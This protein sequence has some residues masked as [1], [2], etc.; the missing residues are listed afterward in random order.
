MNKISVTVY[1]KRVPYRTSVKPS[2]WADG[3]EEVAQHSC[4]EKEQ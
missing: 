1:T 2:P 4:M 3:M